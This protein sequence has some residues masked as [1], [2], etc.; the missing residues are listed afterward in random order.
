MW[1]IAS[2]TARAGISGQVLRTLLPTPARCFCTVRH[3]ARCSQRRRQ[4]SCTRAIQARW[5]AE[6]L[7]LL[8][9]LDN[10][11]L[12]LYQLHVCLRP[13]VVFTV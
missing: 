13:A 7:A 9:L 3:P 4:Q 10:Q 12:R 8:P 11:L 1:S 5:L 6:S 2:P